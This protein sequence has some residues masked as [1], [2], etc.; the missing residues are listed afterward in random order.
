MV[1]KTALNQGMV[2]LVATADNPPEK[3]KPYIAVYLQEEVKQEGQVRNVGDFSR[4]LEIVSFSRG[5]EINA[6]NIARECSV[7]RN[8]PNPVLIS[9]STLTGLNMRLHHPQFTVRKLIAEMAF[10]RAEFPCV[11]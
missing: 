11:A 9:P 1:W 10:G 3:L 4:F 5:A 2:P 8:C 7:S 6:S